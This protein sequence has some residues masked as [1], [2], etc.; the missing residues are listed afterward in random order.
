MP[1]TPLYPLVLR[2]GFWRPLAA[3]SSSSELDSDDMLGE[4]A[5]G[6][7]AVALWSLDAPV[8]AVPPTKDSF[9]GS[10][11]DL[12]FLNL[13]KRDF[14]PLESDLVGDVGDVGDV[15]SEGI[16]F[17]LVVSNGSGTVEDTGSV[18]GKGSV[19]ATGAGSS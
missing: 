14:K 6:E 17:G 8:S 13:L 3:V 1:L 19:E 5:R 18:E 15:G 9:P 7:V 16:D 11:F 4:R 10:C 2:F 12:R